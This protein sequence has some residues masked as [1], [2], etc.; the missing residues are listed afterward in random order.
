[1]AWIYLS[2]LYDT[3]FQASCLVARIVDQ[4]NH[5]LLSYFPPRYVGIFQTQRGRYGVKVL[6]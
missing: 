2:K 1:M 6:L 3:R 4:P 5:Q